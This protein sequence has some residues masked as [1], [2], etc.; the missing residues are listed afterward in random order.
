MCYGIGIGRGRER[1]GAYGLVSLVIVLLWVGIGREEAGA[2]GKG[3][4]GF[5]VGYGW[6]LLWD[7][8]GIIKMG[9]IIEYYCYRIILL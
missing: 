4:G 8:I 2:G 6:V 3:R 9:I 5:E 1:G 7:N